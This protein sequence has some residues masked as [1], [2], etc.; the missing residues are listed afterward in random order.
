MT[1]LLN[2]LIKRNSSQRRLRASLCLG[3][4]LLPMDRVVVNLDLA[5][6]DDLSGLLVV[7]IQVHVVV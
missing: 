2:A 7:V 4:P 5:I 6:E 3:A 1:S